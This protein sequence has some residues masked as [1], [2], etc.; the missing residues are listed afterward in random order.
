MGA[1]KG[2][3][4]HAGVE[5]LGAIVSYRDL[6]MLLRWWHNDRPARW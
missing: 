1:T 3:F 2:I 6:L 5:Q 4:F